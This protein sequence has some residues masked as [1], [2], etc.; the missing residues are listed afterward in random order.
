MHL[1]FLSPYTTSNF[2][3]SAE[4]FYL[5]EIN[6]K[7]QSLV[8]E[9]AVHFKWRKDPYSE[10]NEFELS[11]CFI[12]AIIPVEENK[13]KI[14]FESRLEITSAL[15]GITVDREYDIGNIILLISTVAVILPKF[16]RSERPIKRIRQIINIPALLF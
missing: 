14:V 7:T 13:L 5:I 1:Y 16:I 12:M 2:S 8:K 15:Y 10:E 6:T 3:K 4:G 9:R 11:S